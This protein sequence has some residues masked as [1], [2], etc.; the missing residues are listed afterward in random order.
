MDSRAEIT[1]HFKRCRKKLCQTLT[2]LHNE[3]PGESMGGVNICQR[4]TGHIYDKIVIIMSNGQKLKTSPLRSGARHSWNC[5]SV[6]WSPKSTYRE[7]NKWDTNRKR[8][9]PKYPYLHDIIL[10][11]RNPSTPP[12]NFYSWKTHALK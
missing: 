4:N 11:I 5:Y 8:K 3:N 2:F 6:Y 9:K 7:E 12:E 1:N 10:W